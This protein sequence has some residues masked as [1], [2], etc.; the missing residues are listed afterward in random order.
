MHTPTE[1]AA[2]CKWARPTIEVPSPVWLDAE[3]SPW[4][5]VRTGTP[6]VLD[7]TEPCAACSHWAEDD[8]ATPES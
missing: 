5:C 4:T 7:S 2:N 1:H 3:Q 6:I 8:G